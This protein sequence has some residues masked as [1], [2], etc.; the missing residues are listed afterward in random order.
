MPNDEKHIH[1]TYRD[2]QFA[3]PVIEGSEGE[4]AVD[5]S[6]LKATV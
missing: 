6:T 2:R 1:F 4:R 5:I 3:L